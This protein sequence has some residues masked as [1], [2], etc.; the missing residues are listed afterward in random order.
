M[1]PPIRPTLAARVA[2]THPRF[3]AFHPLIKRPCQ[4]FLCLILLVACGR[5]ESPQPAITGQNTTAT[6][7]LTDAQHNSIKY[8]NDIQYNNDIMTLTAGGQLPTPVITDPTLAVEL[9]ALAS[10]TWPTDEPQPTPKLG[11]RFCGYADRNFDHE[12]CWIGLNAATYV[13]VEAGSPEGSLTDG[14][15]R[16]YTE[17]LTLDTR[18]GREKYQTPTQQGP[19]KIIQANWPFIQVETL[20]APTT[21]FTFNLE[22][23][24]W[25]TAN[26]T[27]TATVEPEQVEKTTMALNDIKEEQTAFAAPD[28]PEIT[29]TDGPPWV[30][31]PPTPNI[32]GRTTPVAGDGYL[33]DDT[34]LPLSAYRIRNAWVY[35][36]DNG[37]WL[38][39]YAGYEQATMSNPPVQGIIVVQE[40]GWTGYGP[41]M[42]GQISYRTP[43]RVGYA[44][45]IDG[46]VDSAETTV[47]V[48]T[49]DGSIFTFNVT[50]SKWTSANG[51]PIA[52]TPTATPIGQ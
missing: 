43:Q 33:I 32:A 22:T 5:I 50:T 12:N 3:A 47:D 30:G 23:R 42:R 49:E 1:V 19:I 24:Q 2:V 41:E 52:S 7:T 40:V 8:A 51:I 34:S 31:P 10:D 44:R 48:R 18:G 17:T 45:V 11:I 35:W 36:D 13:V 4:L 37:N 28:I 15:L 39:V 21:Q 29:P 9:T 16:V 46:R 25:V 20:V 26:G 27:P 38:T 14:L 6:P